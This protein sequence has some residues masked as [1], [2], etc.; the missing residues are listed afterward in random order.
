MN[1]IWNV[2]SS[3]PTGIYTIFLAM[4]L[5]LWL[6][7]IIGAMDIDV[8]SFD[9]DFDT[10]TDIPGFAGLLHTLGL[11]GVPFTIVLTLIIF[12]AW[13]I[14]YLTSIFLT[15][16]IPSSILQF[17]FSSTTLVGSFIIAVFIT[18]KL[19][20]PLRKLSNENKAKTKID[21]LGQPCKVTS[22]TVD[23]EFGQG[24]ISSNNGDDII[25]R[26]RASKA[27]GFK[28]GDIVIAI[29]YN[30]TNNLYQVISNDEFKTNLNK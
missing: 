25:V 4:L 7:T 10:E 18:G 2:L 1:E 17:I 16:L 3:Y 8:V 27:E 24:R 22:L 30:K 9:V 11:S 13:T 29:S 12:L 21:F 26:I 15:P 20:Q 5:V 28:K 19:I 6:F 23:D 14:T